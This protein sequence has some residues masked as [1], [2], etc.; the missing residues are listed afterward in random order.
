MIAPTTLPIT[1][2]GVTAKDE[3]F[4]TVLIQTRRSEKNNEFFDFEEFLSYM[5]LVGFGGYV[6]GGIDPE[7]SLFRSRFHDSL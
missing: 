5:V 7:I 6:V 3:G 1:K 4:A 2:S